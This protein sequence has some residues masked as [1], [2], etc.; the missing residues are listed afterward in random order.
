MTLKPASRFAERGSLFLIALITMLVLTLVG[1]SLAVV[2]E[3]EMILGSNEWTTNETHY[4]AEAGLN[5]QL[6]QLLVVGDPFPV[7]LALPS[8]TPQ[9]SG[10]KIGFD[11]RNSGLSRVADGPLPLSTANEGRSEI[12]YGYYFMASRAQRTAWPVAND[13]PSCA[14]LAKTDLGRKTLVTGL[15][16]APMEG[17]S[18]ESLLDE[19]KAAADATENANSTGVTGLKT[20][21]DQ[22]ICAFEGARNNTF[23]APSGPEDPDTWNPGQP[24]QRSDLASTTASNLNKSGSAGDVLIKG[25]SFFYGYS[26]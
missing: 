12:N 10:K 19:E 21:A 5:V 2:T 14:D 11:V 20:D 4:A 7:P 8:Y 26:G 17:E 15:Y 9:N 1:L 3:T 16:M 18:S 22:P 6:A 24:D 13:V 23:D 25:S